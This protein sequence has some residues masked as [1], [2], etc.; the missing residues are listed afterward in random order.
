[1][2]PLDRTLGLSALMVLLLLGALALSALLVMVML[3]LKRRSADTAD[4]AMLQG[5]RSEMHSLELLAKASA[6]RADAL[7]QERDAR[8][9]TEQDLQFN[10]QLLSRALDERIRLGQDLH[11]HLIQTLYA[12]G[13][14]LDSTRAL[15]DTQPEEVKRRLEQ[16]VGT[17]NGAIREV[18]S[19]IAGLKPEVLRRTGFRTALAELIDLLRAGR[20][21]SCDVRLDEEVL[22][23]L[24]LEQSREI[25]Q[26][27]REA[28]SNS[29]RHGA[30]TALTLRL[31]RDE[32]SFA[33]LVQD[34]GSGFTPEAKHW[35]GPNSGHGLGNMQ[36]RAERLGGRLRWESQA[37]AGTRVI[38]TLPII[39]CP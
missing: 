21:V 29:L 31:H 28:I 7:A 9:R 37:G 30:A 14:T 8:Q 17:I 24:T 34:N 36:A 13:L 2:P 20:D 11:D 35:T 32:Q 4:T 12:M 6:E 27:V 18:R 38:L 26:I 39:G 22:S 19:H 33:L 16:A 25:L 5:M 15:V 23:L 1:M 10:Q 3:W